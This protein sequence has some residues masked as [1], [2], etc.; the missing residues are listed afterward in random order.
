MTSSFTDL[1]DK[2]YSNL[3]KTLLACQNPAKADVDK[4]FQSHAWMSPD[5]NKVV[6]IELDGISKEVIN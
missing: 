2:E 3:G 1:I 4:K 5:G 6:K